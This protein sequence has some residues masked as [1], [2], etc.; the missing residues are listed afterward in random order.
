MISSFHVV[1]T[2]KFISWLVDTAAS[3][4]RCR[5]EAGRGERKLSTKH[6]SPDDCQENI[7]TLLCIMDLWVTV[8]SKHSGRL[9]TC[10]VVLF[11]RGIPFIFL[12]MLI[13]LNASSSFVTVTTHFNLHRFHP[14]TKSSVFMTEHVFYLLFSY[15]SKCGTWGNLA[16][17]IKI[18]AWFGVVSTQTDDLLINTLVL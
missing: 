10:T 16:H 3:H 7:N 15:F 18:L 14:P 9:F 2:L 1:D 5:P 17:L 12:I 8:H 6:K 13:M 11:D 4:S